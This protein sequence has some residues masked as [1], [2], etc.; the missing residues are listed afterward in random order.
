MDPSN[1]IMWAVCIGVAWVIL[2]SLTG[3]DEWLRALFGKSKVSELEKRVGKLERRLE[4]LEQPH[5]PPGST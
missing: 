2:A 4:E 5:K 1:L 3:M